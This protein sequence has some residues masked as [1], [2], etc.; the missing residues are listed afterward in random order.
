MKKALIASILLAV[1]VSAVAVETAKVT[2]VPVSTVASTPA[3]PV[4]PVVKASAK[5]KVV[6]KKAK[7]VATKKAVIT[8]VPTK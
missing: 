8:K 7:K 2:V 3:T 5:K 6:H 1:S 4:T